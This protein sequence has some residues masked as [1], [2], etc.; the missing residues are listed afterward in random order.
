MVRKE[1]AYLVMLCKLSSFEKR[2]PKECEWLH[3]HMK[4]D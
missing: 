1:N 2:S 4:S 3:V